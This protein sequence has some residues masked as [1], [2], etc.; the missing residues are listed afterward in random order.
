MI[1]RDCGRDL[2]ETAFSPGLLERSPAYHRCR[3]CQNERTKKYQKENRKKI[4]EYNRDY[5][6]RRKE[7]V[8]S[9]EIVK[10][11]VKQ[12]RLVKSPCAICGDT[13]VVAHHLSYEKGER[14]KIIWVCQLHN[15]MLHA[16]AVDVTDLTIEKLR[17]INELD[18]RDVENKKMLA[19]YCKTPLEHLLVELLYIF[20][21]QFKELISLNKGDI[22]ISESIVTIRNETYSDAELIKW[23][24]SYLDLRND[25]DSALIVTERAPHKMPINQMRYHLKKVA[26][27]AGIMVR[28]PRV[29]Y[30]KEQ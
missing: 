28:S 13:N 1:C 12:G 11:A 4:T 18:I 15:K 2:P 23:L 24:K 3:V 25:D 16:D 30:N 6:Q 14:Q 20:Q 26:S 27:R 21:G 22:K 19:D 9:M 29:Y 5:R 10:K 7:V 8:R 17:G